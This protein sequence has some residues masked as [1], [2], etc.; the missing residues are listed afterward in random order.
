MDK[1]PSRL[2]SAAVHDETTTDAE[3]LI[4]DHLNG[5]RPEIIAG[6][7]AGLESRDSNAGDMKQGLSINNA[8]DKAKIEFFHCEVCDTVAQ[9]FPELCFISVQ[10]ISGNSM[11]VIT[12]RTLNLHPH[13]G[14]ISRIRVSIS[15]FQYEVHVM[16]KI[17]ESGVLESIADVQE[18][19]NKFSAQS[20]YKFCPGIDPQHYKLHYYEVIRFDIKS[21]RQTIEPFARIDSVNCK[22]WH[23]L[24]SNATSAEK[25]CSEVRC[26][27]CKRLVTDL[28]CQ[29]RRTLAESPGRKLK[30][31]S[32]S[33]RARLTYMS[34]TSQQR[35]KSNAQSER[36]NMRKLEKYSDAD[37]TLN[38]EQHDEM[39][40]V[41]ERIS[42]EDLDK[43]FLEGSEHG[44]GDLMKEIWYTDRK[45][46]QQQFL[47]D[48]SKN[49]KF[50]LATSYC[51]VVM[52]F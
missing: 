29:R 23:T 42:N 46:Q 25:S 21:I 24:A 16:I 22:L 45:R 19:C 13:F 7:E 51:T 31:Q 32:S 12:Q 41:V 43:I 36:S 44:V 2:V 38:D 26:S 3:I 5:M 4:D 18:L 17:W 9:C 48:Q 27:A 37:V 14:Y 1:T 49:C 39:C 28:D 15:G 50:S 52:V 30:R 6:T 11:V 34:P 47:Q 8:A 40:S 10:D 20:S 33:S 35:R